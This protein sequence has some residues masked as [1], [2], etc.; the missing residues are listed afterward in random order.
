MKLITINSIFIIYFFLLLSC[1]N[2]LNQKVYQNESIAKSFILYWDGHDVEKLTSLFA[3]SCLYEEVASGRKYYDKNGIA[4]YASSTL[5]GVP[6]SK[7]EIVTISAGDTIAFVEWNWSGTN[8]VGW[9]DMGLLPS[10]KHFSL[11]GVSVMVI[12]D[13]KIVR[14][15]DY[16]DWNSFIQR[17]E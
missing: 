9:P 7:F 8:S 16:W 3:D 17:I 6:D 10:G 14:N 5:S 15:S 2:E 12:K 13:N 11:R 4:G 1:S